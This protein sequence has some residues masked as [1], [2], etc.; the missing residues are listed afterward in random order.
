M[1]LVLVDRAS[2]VPIFNT[3]VISNTVVLVAALFVD[4][5]AVSVCFGA[6][7]DEN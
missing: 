5:A 6:T 2:V 4:M 7:I 3:A 1:K